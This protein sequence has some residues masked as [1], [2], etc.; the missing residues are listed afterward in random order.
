MARASRGG[1]GGRSL[2]AAHAVP[3]VA[4][5]PALCILAL[6]LGC[7]LDTMPPG[8][9][10]E[11]RELSVVGAELRIRVRA[12]TG[13]YVG[14]IEEFADAA[15]RDCGSDPEVRMR[16]LEWKLAAIPQVQDALFQPDPLVGLLDGWA[17]AVQ[18]RA[19]LESPAGGVAFGECRDAAAAAMG[20][21]AAA[22][23][24]IADEI[25]PDRGQVAE[26][27][28][29][30]WAAAH[31]LRSLFLPRPTIAPTAAKESARREL[32][33]LA[34]VGTIV[35]TLDDL[36]ARVAAYRQTLLKEAAWTGELAA[37]RATSSD[38]A[39]Q[40]SEDVRHIAAAMERIGRLAERIPVVLERERAAAV[41]GLRAEREQILEEIDRQRAETLALLQGERA[42]VLDRIDAMSRTAVD[43]V[44][45][46]TEALVDHAFLRA[47]QLMLGLLAASAIAA[48]LVAW[49]LGFRLRAVRSGR[50][51]R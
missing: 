43:D 10:A 21:I 18:M 40:A 47:A 49:A 1:K 42:A 46:R 23:R 25:A 12:L 19:W 8:G 48:V 3:S 9:V 11:R 34:A 45:S 26:E 13:P 39:L 5:A 32:G 28:V 14:A 22:A 37:L 7:R 17:Y 15:A 4:F 30:K 33:A 24:K 29:R 36:T 2:A 31:P 16:A 20:R 38:V 6:L 50:S 27:L 35:E 51:P 44:G 41:T